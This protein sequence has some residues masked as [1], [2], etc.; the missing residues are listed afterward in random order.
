MSPNYIFFF[1]FFFSLRLWQ[2]C[3]FAMLDEV[4]Y[5]FNIRASD[6]E[7]RVRGE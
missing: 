2:L 4:A 1:F 6:V 3:L 7:V 5:I